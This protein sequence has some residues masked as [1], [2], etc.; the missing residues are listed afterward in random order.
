MGSACGVNDYQVNADKTWSMSYNSVVPGGPMA[1]VHFSMLV[2]GTI[3]TDLCWGAATRCNDNNACTTDSCDPATGNCGHAPV[4][5]DD[6]NACTIDSCNPITGVK[7]TPINCDDNN[8][9]TTDSC[10]PAVG[11]VHQPIV[12][13]DGDPCTIDSCDKVLG[14]IPTPMVC[15][16]GDACTTDTCVNGVCVFTPII[17]NDNNACTTEACVNGVC[18]TTSTKNCDDGNLCTNDSCNPATGA[19]VN[20]PKCAAG[21]TCDPAVGQCINACPAGSVK[22]VTIRGGGQKPSGADLQIETSF[23]VMNSGCIGASTASTLACTPGTVLQVNFRAGY[24][25]NPTSATWQSNTIPAD[26]NFTFT[27]TAGNVY[28]LVLDNK[29]AVGGKDTDRIT[30]NV[31]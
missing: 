10:N 11:C 20:A 2:R 22:T 25:P 28:K 18:V 4:V 15:N 1:G 9:C 29:G 12:C 13:N 8:A 24:G 19:C 16:D 7:H 30:V 31:Q 23:T 14:C 17:C 6:G 5:I 21:Q 26:T 27:C 3:T